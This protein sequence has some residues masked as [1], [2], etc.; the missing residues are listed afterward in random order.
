MSGMRV[1][2]GLWI[3]VLALWVIWSIRTKATRSREGVWSALSYRVPTIA[4]YVLMF[5]NALPMAWLRVP[6]FSK[7]SSVEILGIAV[8]V[9]GL[10]LAIWAR[11]YL[12]GN[13]SSTVTVKVGHE[14]V[15]S[16]PYRWVRHPIYSGLILAML[17]TALERREWRGWLAVALLYFGFALKS[18][19]EERTMKGE[20]GA[21][22]DEYRRRTGAI[23]PRLRL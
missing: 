20:F 12:G 21:A 11:G 10:G 23:L 8:T 5:S 2:E 7:T 1:C 16:G 17:G 3:A 19:I 22:Y 15:R 14:L 18:R 9:A 13:W 6:V 4:A